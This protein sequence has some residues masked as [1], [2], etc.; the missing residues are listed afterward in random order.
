MCAAKLSIPK[1]ITGRTLSIGVRTEDIASWL[2]SLPLADH[3]KAVRMFLPVLIEFNRIE[4]EAGQ[5]YQILRQL[6]AVAIE[7]T[8]GIQQKYLGSNAGNIDRR[9]L[10]RSAVVRRMQQELAYGYKII[11]SKAANDP[12]SIPKEQVAT[13]AF[14]AMYCL[15]R[16]QLEHYMMY[17]PV[18]GNVWGEINLLYRYAQKV[19]IHNLPL[20]LGKGESLSIE[21]IYLRL[22]LLA[23]INP[24]RLMRGEAEK[25]YI[26][27]KEW[28]HLSRLDS[29]EPGWMP[30]GEIIIDLGAD[31][32]PEHARP[33]EKYTDLSL[34]RVLNIEDIKTQL[35]DLAKKSGTSTDLGMR[36]KQDMLQRLVGGWRS[37]LA[38]DSERTEF[39]AE[40]ELVIGLKDCNAIY[41]GSEFSPHGEVA[42]S[43]E[44]SLIPLELQWG[45]AA[46]HGKQPGSSVFR[47]D[48]PHAD[49]WDKKETLATTPVEE[50]TK[51]D[52]S[53]FDVSQIDV[54]AGGYGLRFDVES[55][56]QVRVGEV[57]CLRLK[58][59]SGGGPW[60]VGDVRWKRL[61]RE[62]GVMF[63][64]RLLAEVA[65]PFYAT[66]VKGL[67]SGADATRGL[68][69]PADGFDNPAASLLL[70][71]TI[72][73]TTTTLRIKS[74]YRA[75]R[76]QLSEKLEASEGFARFA[77]KVLE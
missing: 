41:G 9:S 18:A 52:V 69:I 65:E 10:E 49:I 48:D 59:I 35:Q 43:D 76:V 46:S 20:T 31:K 62:K 24:Y 7:I 77:F 38:R 47:I 36:L 17:E 6:T 67:G 22:L 73:D 15:V 32:S 3:E 56:I 39:A 28:C 13:S 51:T 70:P 27:M 72:F 5:R 68:L 53:R 14:Y 25:I 40:M 44:L 12:G 34:I 54:S 66:A 58:D 1:Q 57:V 37:S 64:V 23:A 2:D 16:F 74:R 8:K 21:E 19:R 42:R 33:G 4:I 61:D 75:L 11:I 71:A 55:N 26:M 63:G 30:N 29:C 50:G 45:T 60:R